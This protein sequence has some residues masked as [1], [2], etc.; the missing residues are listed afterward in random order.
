MADS[1]RQAIAKRTLDIIP[2]IMRVMSAE[3]RQ[4]QHGIQPG[5]LA[6]L[7]ILRCRTHTLSDLADRLSVS[8]P[9]MSNTIN[10]LEE[11]G[12]VQRRRSEVDRRVVW[13]EITDAGTAMM[14]KVN[15]DVEARLTTLLTALDDA[16]AGVLADGLA[17]L[18]DVF[19]EALDGDPRLCGE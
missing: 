5:H 11:R 3:M 12:W 13:V 8:P 18:R 4:T 2:L 9:T 7:G 1:N 16:Q 15:S 17:V 10:A 19:T 14:E 6:L